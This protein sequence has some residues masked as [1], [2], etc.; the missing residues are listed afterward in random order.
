MCCTGKL[1][2]KLEGRLQR[3]KQSKK[4]GSGKGLKI[5]RPVLISTVSVTSV[6]KKRS[7]VLV[8]YISHCLEFVLL[9]LDT[10]TY[11][12]IYNRECYLNNYSSICHLPQNVCS[13]SHFLFLKTGRTFSHFIVNMFIKKEVYNI[14]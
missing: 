3:G 5:N 1:C 8:S 2:F 14:L 10:H 12:F 6:L 11:I 7:T 13:I 9:M 4:T